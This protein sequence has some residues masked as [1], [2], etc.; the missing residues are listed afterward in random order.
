VRLATALPLP[1]QVRQVTRI[2]LST[3]LQLRTKHNTTQQADLC[4]IIGRSMHP[5][6]NSQAM[7]ISESEKD[8]QY[9][10]HNARGNNSKVSLL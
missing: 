4:Q 1:N 9:F 3:I 6:R 7:M 10:L 8:Q 5:A 2:V